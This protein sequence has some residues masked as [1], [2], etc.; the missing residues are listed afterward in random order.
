MTLFAFPSIAQPFRSYSLRS[1][2]KR[3]EAT[4]QSSA[5][6]LGPETPLDRLF[7]SD[8]PTPATADN[9]AG[10]EDADQRLDDRLLRDFDDSIETGFQIATFQG[11]LCGEPV[12]GMAYFVENVDA[13]SLEERE[14]REC[15]LI[16]P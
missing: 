15:L 5:S 11:P 7:L 9:A 16:R 4:V 14:S 12:V 10:N 3:Y 13:G 6:S 2:R 8:S 1:L